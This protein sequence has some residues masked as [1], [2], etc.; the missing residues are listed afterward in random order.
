MLP[1]LLPA[2]PV[3][4]PAAPVPVCWSAASITSF[5][6]R[7]ELGP[8]EGVEDGADPPQVSATFV[9]LVTLNC[10][11]PLLL[12]PAVPV[13]ELEFMPEFAPVAVVAV[14]EALDPA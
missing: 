7:S 2:A 11:M 9:A 10:F 5:L 14:E 8:L 13:F 12:A 6:C 3:P 4:V 1:V